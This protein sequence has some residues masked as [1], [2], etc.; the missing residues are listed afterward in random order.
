MKKALFS[1]SLF[2]ILVSAALANPG[3]SYS[4]K[5]KSGTIKIEKQA[6]NSLIGDLVEANSYVIIQFNEIP[7]SGSKK[8]IES[9][10]IKLLEY[11]PNYS[12]L[13][14]VENPPDIQLQ[15]LNIR[16]IISFKKEFKFSKFFS[17]TSY[18]NWAIPTRG[19]VNLMIE[20]H[21]DVEQSTFQETM[22]LNDVVIKYIDPSGSY[23]NI[24]IDQNSIHKLA[25]I[26]IVK[27]ID[28]IP[29]PPEKE[30]D[31]ARSLHR[32]NMLDSD[33]PLGRKYDG[34]GISI[35]LA[36]DGL[37]GPHIDYT[38]RVTQFVNFDNGSHGD[39]T[40]GIAIG[41]GNLNPRIRGAA[42]GASLFYYNISGY[43]HIANAVTN[44]TNRDIVI[45]STSYSEGCNAGYTSTTRV[46]D[47]Q[48]RQNPELL[49]VFSAGNSSGSTCGLNAYGAGTPWGTITG[50]RKQ[51][52]S[53]IATGN[54][55]FLG[56]LTNS[57]S[58]GPA[59]DGRIKPDICSNGTNQLSTDPNNE[60]SPGGGTSAA[61][62]SIAGTAAQ[63]YQGYKELHNGTNPESGLIKSVML[64]TAKN[65]GFAGPDYYYGWGQINAH[66][67]MLLIEEDRYL[68]TTIST[69]NT[70][71][72]TINI[73]QDL[74]ELRFMV[75]WTDFEASTIASQAL[76]NDLDIKVVT[77]NGDTILP[78][79]LDPTANAAA[80]VS[81]A[82]RGVDTLNN[83]EQ[84][85]ID[86][87][88][89]GNY[90]ILINGTSVPQG[91]QKYFLSWETRT[92]E[93]HITYPSG[94]ESFVPS[95]SETIRWDAI[96]DQSSFQIEYS[97]DSGSTWNNISFVSGRI[98]SRTWFVPDSISGNA[99][100]RVRRTTGPST[101]GSSDTSDFTFSIIKTPS[102][103]KA[104][105]VCLDS[106]RISWDTVPGATGYEISML[107]NKYMDSI[108][109]SDTNYFIIQNADFQEDNW[110]SVKALGINII[111]RRANAVQLS[112]EISGC[113]YKYD[114]G[115]QK[116]ISPA[117]N[118][119]LSCG[120]NTF[121]VKI[122]VI[123]K[124]DSSISNAPLS[125]VINNIIYRDTLVG[126]LAP[127]SSIVFI[128]KDSIN[129]TLN[130][131]NNIEVKGIIPLDENYTNDSLIASFEVIQSNSASL[132]LVNNFDANTLCPTTSNCG[133]TNCSL[134]NGWINTS[135]ID[136]DDFDMRV[137]NGG[138]PSGGTGPFNDHTLGNSAG[139]YIYSEASNN[140]YDAESHV[141]SP[142]VDLAGTKFPELSFWYH[143]N[144]TSVGSLSVD[145]YSEGSWTEDILN[146][147]EGNQ[148]TS[149]QNKIVD[150]SSFIGQVIN[151]RFRIRTGDSF[152]SDIAIDDIYIGDIVTNISKIK[153]SP[154]FNLYPNPAK[155][156]LTIEL[157][158]NSSE[159]ILIHDISGRLVKR[160]Q[161]NSSSTTIDISELES[162]LYFISLERV[163]I[164]EKLIVY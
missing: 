137:N 56:T 22:R 36:D 159:T 100:I 88:K 84:V 127:D 50:G 62:P 130:G 59:S 75:Y 110:V 148:G 145:V 12:F 23:Y 24:E 3:H 90:T 156:Q 27:F 66:R 60:Y 147:I 31:K 71:T 122:E 106:I 77:P 34:T 49:H 35:S 78:W 109:R 151:I 121:P 114:F 64:N 164:K 150:L 47:Q 83:V 95:T 93:I 144:G 92:D 140:C 11:L 33:H 139:Q 158:N 119:I 143:M 15:T 25:A 98:R 43:P 123:N 61:A 107:G 58:R 45:T 108:G 112:K 117:D 2:L 21:L 40:S 153:S 69:N 55:T 146:P 124:G 87:A 85:F 102:N 70:N 79:I 52:K 111:G 149:W 129:A 126:L 116:I 99:F 14:F 74:L 133:G 134:S 46:V 101:F 38:G 120:S 135:S 1:L 48:T 81:A 51:G 125:Y 26:D 118:Y 136:F 103:I 155:N 4:L 18:P 17:K 161:S 32:G 65:L 138:T 152:S 94:G 9:N 128:F 63:L 142:C 131:Q 163:G 160:F 41:A 82:R 39:M 28:Y 13:A 113:N 76:V 19:R 6:S 73:P 105:F 115:I 16:G 67:A 42:P 86:S 10:G 30:D 54:L 132:P 37:I 5:L 7:S 97:I 57:S 8:N 29:A 104:D 96:G 157:E 141:I 72:H 162:G 91:P 80:L 44:L 68:D 20:T 53:V 89:S 154:S